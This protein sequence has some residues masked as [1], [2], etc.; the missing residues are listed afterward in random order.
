M[1]TPFTN[2]ATLT[3]NGTT[4]RSNIAVGMMESSLTVTKNAV[5]DAYSA[6]DVL[7]YVISIVNSG[8]TPLTGLS[9]RD[10]MGAYAFGAGAVQPLTYVDGSA[11][12]Y[13]NGVLQPDP[14]VTTADGLTFGDI[15]VPAGGSALIVYRAAVNSY[16]P[17]AAG[18][19][20]DNTAE[21][22]GA[23]VSAEQA[24]ESIPAAEAA[25]LTLLK[26]VS[27]V[28]VTAN[29]QL[30]YTMQLTNTG[31]TAVTDAVIGDVFD[32]LLSGIS[33]A[34]DGA[35]LSPAGYTYDETTGVFA[36]A[37]GVITVPSATYAQDP[38]TGE[39]T[40]TPGTAT[41]T[42]TGAAAAV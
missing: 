13:L 27:P 36:T 37:A 12:L 41:L 31:N 33:V 25:E 38:V 39:W 16:A 3:Y 28:P 11:L 14:T 7:T 24:Q 17:L 26:S 22:S 6:G 42:V 29:G 19:S 30:T 2:Q 34:L 23:S 20:I 1:A 10:N 35:P 9:V 4:V 21:V 40:T 8:T 5:A 32:P 15:D 18:S